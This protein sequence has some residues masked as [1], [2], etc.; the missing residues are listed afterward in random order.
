VTEQVSKAGPYELLEVLHRGPRAVTYVAIR[1]HSE[2]EV[3]LKL[4]TDP[5]RGEIPPD[6]AA[7]RGLVHRHI[8][9]ILDQGEDN[10]FPY[11]VMERLRGRTLG[12]LMTDP[13]FT[14]DLP[15]RVDLIA[16]LCIGLHYAHERHIVHG[17]V[18]PDNIFITDDG[19]TKILNFGAGSVGSDRT[20]VSDHPLA[21]SFEYMSPEQII[22][23]DAV[24]GRSDVFSTAIV[25]YELIAGRRPFQGASTTATLA[26]ILRDDPAPL[27]VPP[28][29]NAILRRGLEKEAAKRYASAQEFAYALWMMDL[30]D[31]GLD[32]QEVD[33]GSDVNETMYVEPTADAAGAEGAE[34]APRGGA[35]MSK[36]MLIYGGAAAAVLILGAAAFVSC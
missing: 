11:L 2:Q 19:V 10:G 8:V 20:M 28:R 34:Q 1:E 25:L 26:R 3:V 5:A 21:G 9:R 32:R 23:K 30:P 27:D 22:G 14:A 17:N 13:T 33:D 4:A 16:Q 31:A 36:Q 15:T 35:A 6:V 12:E 18:R 7:A 29:L 24:D